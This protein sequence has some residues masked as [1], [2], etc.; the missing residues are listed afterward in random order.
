MP[1]PISSV[2]VVGEGSAGLLAALA[3][4]TQF[5]QLDVQ[6]LASTRKPIIGVGESTTGS[7]PFFLHSNLDL[8][9]RRFHRA[10]RPTWKVG[11]RFERWGADASN[12]FNFAFDK[13]ILR[14]DHRLPLRRGV[15]YGALGRDLALSSALIRRH[16]SPILR[17]SVT[18]EHRFYPFGYHI[19]NQRFTAFLATVARERGIRFH[20]GEL[21]QIFTDESGAVSSIQID[22]GESYTADFFVDCTGF[23]SR[24]LNHLGV[25]FISYSDALA[26]DTAIVGEWERDEPIRACTTCTTMECGWMWRIEHIE[27]INQAYVFSSNHIS[28]DDARAEYLR[29][30]RRS[31]SQVRT[32]RF[33]SGRYETCWVKNVVAVGNSSGFVEPLESTGLHMISSQVRWLIRDLELGLLCLSAARIANYNVQAAQRWDDVRDFI[34]IHYK[35]NRASGSEFWRWCNSSIP[36]GALQGFVD[37]Y[38]EVG[39][40]LASMIPDPGERGFNVLPPWS[41]FGFAGYLTLLVGMRV[42]TRVSPAIDEE[43][44]RRCDE[45][46][47]L[48]DETAKNALTIDEAIA[49]VHDGQLEHPIS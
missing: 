36:L 23:S 19:E 18:G 25:K 30:T 27:K 33:P 3:L 9:P 46:W 10:V 48:L 6:I 28:E 49:A 45:L 38:E 37:T 1:K 34:A 11:L 24:F 21:R 15:Y 16:K 8:E 20:D 32:I 47:G 5:P 13:Q 2:L 44:R 4:K 22:T 17:D 39:P 40:A 26:C 35:F 29:E 41:I 31:P 43:D 7:I 14:Q 12:S 42:P